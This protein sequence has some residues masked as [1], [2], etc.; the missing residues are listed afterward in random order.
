MS[1]SMAEALRGRVRQQERRAQTLLG[2][3]S[4]RGWKPFKKPF[5]KP[6]W[7]ICYIHP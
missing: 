1:T 5:K 6:K 3:E 2:A 4:Q 7:F